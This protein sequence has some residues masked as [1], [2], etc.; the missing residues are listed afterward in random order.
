MMKLN[1]AMMKLEPGIEK[2]L[3]DENK[4]VWAIYKMFEHA[5]FKYRKSLWSI[6]DESDRREITAVVELNRTYGQKK[7]A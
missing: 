4:S 3:Y 5:G 6:L 7:T 2:K 1:G